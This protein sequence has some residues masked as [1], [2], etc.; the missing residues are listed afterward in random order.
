LGWTEKPYCEISLPLGSFPDRIPVQIVP[1]LFLM[2]SPFGIYV[3]LGVWFFLTGLFPFFSDGEIF[4]QLSGTFGPPLG[5]VCTE[6]FFPPLA[7]LHLRPPHRS[8]LRL[9]WK[10][11]VPPAPHHG[12]PC[13]FFSFLADWCFIWECCHFL[14]WCLLNFPPFS[15]G[16]FWY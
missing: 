11:V 6:F 16:L 2:A 13:H 9:V 5:F 12:L 1:L 3:S 8:F 15:G 14:F 4:L 10:T 7:V